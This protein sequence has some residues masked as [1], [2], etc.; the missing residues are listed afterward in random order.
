LE[1][2]LQVCLRHADREVPNPYR[3]LPA[4]IAETTDLLAFDPALVADLRQRHYRGWAQ[5]DTALGDT[6]VVPEMVRLSLCQLEHHHCDVHNDELLVELRMLVLEWERAHT[7]CLQA[8]LM[9]GLP[10]LA[11]AIMPG[12]FELRQAERDAFEAVL[13]CAL[14]IV[15][16]RLS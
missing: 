5:L 9:L 15:A 6:G 14:E 7:E 10:G 16:M 8:T 11:D 3:R 4:G 13:G 1:R 12:V 2:R